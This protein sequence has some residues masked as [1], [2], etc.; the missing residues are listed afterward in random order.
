VNAGSGSLLLDNCAISACL[1]SGGWAAVCARFTVETVREVEIEAT[2]G[3]QHREIVDPREFRQL[4]AVHDV[5]LEQRF[6]AQERYPQLANLDAGE[7]DL[8]VHAL[9]RGDGWI[10]CGPD[11]AS[12]KFGI[13]AGHADRLISLEEL[14]ERIG[15]RPQSPLKT[16]H[17]K[18]WLKDLIATTKLDMIFATRDACNK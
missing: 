7:R 12:I 8:W 1:E 14:F 3:Y 2:T 4:V 6:D 11:V 10:L 16:A 18:K 15:Y 13:H 9:V 5:P 17:T